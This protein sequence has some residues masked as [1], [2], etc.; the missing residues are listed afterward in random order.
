MSETTKI[1]SNEAFS[2]DVLRVSLDFNSQ[3]LSIAT[4]ELAGEPSGKNKTHQKNVIANL[5]QLGQQYSR[6]LDYFY[7]EREAELRGEEP[8]EGYNKED[9]KAIRR[10]IVILDEIMKTNPS[11]EYADASNLL[12][13]MLQTTKGEGNKNA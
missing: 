13:L 5:Q 12:S 8:A 7:D 1:R 9:T 10:T 11:K 6:R 3:V 4:S 2:M